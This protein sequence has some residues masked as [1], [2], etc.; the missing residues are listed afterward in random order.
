[1]I[2]LIL[3]FICIFVVCVT[4]IFYFKFGW[5]FSFSLFGSGSESNESSNTLVDVGGGG[6]FSQ[7]YGMDARE[8]IADMNA[9]YPQ[10]TLEI[11]SK[12]NALDQTNNRN[13]RVRIFVN[14]SGKIQKMVI[15]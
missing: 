11:V 4:M 10:Y 14:L 9:T 7:Y 6:D 15:G 5:N 12:D 2:F 1:M 13:D 8:V 3:L